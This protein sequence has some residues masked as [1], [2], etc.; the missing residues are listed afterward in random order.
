MIEIKRLSLSI[1][2]HFCWYSFSYMISCLKILFYF[3]T[4]F[5]AVVKSQCC[6]IL[7]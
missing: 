1:N 3:L 5:G 7:S 6:V 4:F 2:L